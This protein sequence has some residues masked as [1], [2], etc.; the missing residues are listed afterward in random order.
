[1][2]KIIEAFSKAGP[3]KLPNSSRK[4]FDGGEKSST[5]EFEDEWKAESLIA[6]KCDRRVVL[7]KMKV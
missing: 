1:V 5:N 2:A 6:W 4:N 7:P 3:L